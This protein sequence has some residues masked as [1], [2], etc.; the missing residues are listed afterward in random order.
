MKETNRRGRQMERKNTKVL[1]K[2]IKQ[3]NT[4]RNQNLRKIGKEMNENGQR[5][6]EDPTIKINTEEI[7]WS[8]HFESHFNPGYIKLETPT[9]MEHITNRR[10]RQIRRRKLNE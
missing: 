5:R 9:E 10:G 1:T 6:Q 7:S 2:E 3:N 4:L 8:Q